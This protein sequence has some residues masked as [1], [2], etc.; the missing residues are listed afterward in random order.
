M[1]L[2]RQDKLR[3]TAKHPTQVNDPSVMPRALMEHL[4]PEFSILVNLTILS[5]LLILFI[6]IGVRSR[7][8]L[9]LGM[10][11]AALNFYEKKVN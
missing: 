11:L 8:I 1:S 7:I 4:D 10:L 5:T 2:E 3:L 9:S 6:D